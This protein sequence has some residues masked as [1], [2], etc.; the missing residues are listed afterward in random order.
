MNYTSS[1][2]HDGTVSCIKKIV[3][4][5][6]TGG[7]SDKNGYIVLVER[8]RGGG[9]GRKGESCVRATA[10]VR[11]VCGVL[12]KRSTCFSSQNEEKMRGTPVT[13]VMHYFAILPVS[14]R[15]TERRRLVRRRLSSVASGV[16]LFSGKTKSIEREKNTPL[17]PTALILISE[18][19]QRVLR[20]ARYNS[21]TSILVKKQIFARYNRQ[22]VIRNCISRSRCA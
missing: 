4:R 7:T 8:E 22:F 12:V 10:C 1:Q 19:S 5:Q 13:C 6:N 16:H 15:N 14:L 11:R 17:R 9:E 18:Y 21:V 20:S 3:Y 2:R